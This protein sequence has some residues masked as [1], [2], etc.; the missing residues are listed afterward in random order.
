MFRRFEDMT[1]GSRI[2]KA[3]RAHLSKFS[4][5]RP[6]NGVKPELPSQ[7]VQPNSDPGYAGGKVGSYLETWDGRCLR[8]ERL[9]KRHARYLTPN[10]QL[11][12]H[13]PTFLPMFKPFRGPLVT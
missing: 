9:E 1:L 8:H 2:T 7:L 12:G 11:L 13:G 5:L 10:L 4:S 6:Q 3:H